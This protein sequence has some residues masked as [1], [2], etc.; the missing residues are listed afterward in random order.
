[1]EKLDFPRRF[2]DWH[3]YGS[4]WYGFD[5]LEVAE[6]INYFQDIMAESGCIMIL[7]AG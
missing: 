5:C 6:M 2:R 4:C 7:L 3:S 1:M